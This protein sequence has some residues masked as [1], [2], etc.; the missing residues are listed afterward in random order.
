MEGMTLMTGELTSKAGFKDAL[1]TA[2]SYI[3]IAVAFGILGKTNGLDLLSVMLLSVI[4]YTGSAQFVIIGMLATHSSIWSIVISTFLISSRMSL[5]SLTVAL[6]LNQESLGHNIWLGSLLTD[7]TFALSMNKLNYT[8]RKLNFFWLNAANLL[9]YSVWAAATLFGALVG[10]LI[11]NP[12]QLGL[13]FALVAMFI[14]LMYLQLVSDRLLGYA[15]QLVVVLIVAV[16]F[17]FS[18]I[19]F[20]ANAAL[21]VAVFVGS[22]AGVV[23]KQ[24]RQKHISC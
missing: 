16:S 5:M 2:L 14:G 22:F 24:W 7:E 15:L 11:K 12:E 13:S 1:P 6:Y 10:N 23:V 4:T 20:S 3:S 19:Y 21:L 9:A 18:L 8:N 17:Y